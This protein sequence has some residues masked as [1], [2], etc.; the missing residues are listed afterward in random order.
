MESIAARTEVDE[1]KGAAKIR[2][3]INKS[4]CLMIELCGCSLLDII[5]WDGCQPERNAAQT[6]TYKVGSPLAHLSGCESLF[7]GISSKTH[8]EGSTL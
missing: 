4:L 6:T 7:K 1:F 8:L 3:D 2:L 5:G